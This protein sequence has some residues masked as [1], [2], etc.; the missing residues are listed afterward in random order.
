[1]SRFCIAHESLGVMKSTNVSGA[2][3]SV[4]SIPRTLVTLE[5]EDLYTVSREARR[6]PLVPFFGASLVYEN[7][8][9]FASRLRIDWYPPRS[10]T[11]PGDPFVAQS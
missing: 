9:S 1:M 3:V 4:A 8:P 10:D 2:S 7:S 5:S 6:N 11:V